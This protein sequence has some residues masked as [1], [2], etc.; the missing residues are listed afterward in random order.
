MIKKWN[1]YNESD[2]YYSKL[3]NSG[4]E[5]SKEIIDIISTQGISNNSY[6][7][8]FH[9]TI[10]LNKDEISQINS[11]LFKYFLER[12]KAKVKNINY[13]PDFDDLPT[14][15]PGIEKYMNCRSG[16]CWFLE[17]PDKNFKGYRPYGIRLELL[18]NKLDNDYYIATINRNYSSDWYLVSSFD[19][20][21]LLIK[22]KIIDTSSVEI[23]TSKTKVIN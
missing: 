3:K 1:E 9:C 14:R 4:T 15:Y 23:K 17:D 19:D 18:V 11:I 10:P 16:Y 2:S 13:D 20:L 7:D 22:E 21:L 5:P 8:G 6:G 12:Y